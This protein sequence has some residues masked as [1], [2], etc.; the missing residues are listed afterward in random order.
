MQGRTPIVTGNRDVSPKVC[1][2]VLAG[3]TALSIV[4][5]GRSLSLPFIAD[6]YLQILLARQYGPP[7]G[8]G[9]VAM[10]ALYRCRET[11]LILTWLTERWVGLDPFWYNVSSLLIHV[12]NTWL[13]FCLG[14]WAMNHGLAHSSERDNPG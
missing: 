1:L 14:A 13:V 8:W 2:L 5:Y 7:S 4:A 3:L 9:A 6:D 11:S 12:A 10:D